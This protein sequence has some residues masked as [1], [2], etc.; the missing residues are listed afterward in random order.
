MPLLEAHRLGVAFGSATAITDLSLRLTKGLALGVTGGAGAGKTTLALAIGGL[1]PRG[2]K[3]TGS[4][5]FDGSALPLD[6]AAMA[7]IRS[8][9]LA[10]LFDEERAALHP[11]VRVRAEVA[12]ALRLRGVAD[13]L[14]RHGS[15]LL[16]EVGLAGHHASRYPHELSAEERHRAMLALALAGNP[17]L[18]IADEPARGLDPLAERRILD[19]IATI[20]DRRNLTLLLLSRDPRAVADLCSE[21]MVLRGGHVIESGPRAQVFG[22]PQ[23]DHTRELL[24]AGRRRGGTLMRSPIGADLVTA[25]EVTVSFRGP[26][27]LSGPV[28]A[29][30][31]VSFAIR[32]SEALAIVGPEG[33]GKSSIARIVA[34]LGRATKG[35]VAFGHERYRG[36]DLPAHLRRDI[37]FV[38]PDPSASFSRRLTLGESAMEPLQLEPALPFEEQAQRLVDLLRAAGLSPE[39]LARYP[40]D[41][42][43]GQLH[44]LA[45]VRALVARPRLVVLDEPAALL[46]IEQRSELLALLNRLRADYGLTYLIASRD[47]EAV[48]SIAD[49]VLILE[50]GKVVEEGKPGVAFQFLD[51]LGER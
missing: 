30:D 16:S 29:V 11:L 19:L 44:R 41:C 34:G 20:R 47:F 1:L 51:E 4:L 37:S 6:E 21:V 50:R 18:L 24:A 3:R 40:Q 48:R 42:S 12:N 35:Y 39:M 45:L 28:V 17:E 36:R 33:S 46:D 27:I 8:R 31:N 22:R 23:H 49:R 5:A 7:R 13:D 15:A 38:F 2:A 10:L 43:L 26:R 25:K 9:R 32:R 14:H